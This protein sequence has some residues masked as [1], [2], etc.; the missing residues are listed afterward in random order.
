[1]TSCAKQTGF[2]V[3]RELTEHQTLCAHR[4]TVLFAARDATQTV[5]MYCTYVTTY[6]QVYT[7]TETWLIPEV[8]LKGESEEVWELNKF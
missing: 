1:M 6:R 8:K 2:T 7:A 4:M 5:D 3:R